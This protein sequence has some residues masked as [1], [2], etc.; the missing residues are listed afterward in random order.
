MFLVLVIFASAISISLTAAY[1]SIVGLATMFPGS[2]E[3]IIIMGAVLE[4]GKLVAAV[5]LHKEWHSAFKFIRNYLLIAV[6]VLSVITSMGIFGF[7]SR[8]H[9]EHTASI[10]KEQAL[11]S[12]IEAKIEREKEFISKKNELINKI[13]SRQSSSAGNK[14]ETISRLTDRIKEIKEESE[15]AIKEQKDSINKY[16]LRIKELDKQLEESKSSGLFSNNKN[17]NKIISKQKEERESISSLISGHEDKSTEVRSKSLES[18]NK[19]REQIDS[20]NSE[21]DVVINVDPNISK[22]TLEVDGAYNRIAELENQSFEYGQGLRA[23]ETEMG[24]ITYIVEAI[25]DWTGADLDT[26]KG[27]RIVIITLIFVFDPLAILLLIAAT[28]SYAELKR[29]KEEGNLPPDV[30]E[31]RNKL[32]EEIEEYL[33]EGG[34]AEHFIERAKK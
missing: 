11:V 18:I 27:I 34:I 1:F 12:Q 16:E 7:L 26:G 31:I 24:P 8:S 21:K 13:E 20:A 15:L 19:I 9:V 29:K 28:M 5:W 4:V 25:K 10:E 22:Y 2:K 30:R 23:L 6:V 17:Y 33:D 14:D 32:L 3:A